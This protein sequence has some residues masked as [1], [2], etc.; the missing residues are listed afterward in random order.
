MENYN[1]FGWTRSYDLSTRTRTRTSEPEHDAEA[2]LVLVT[3]QNWQIFKS[4]SKCVEQYFPGW[5]MFSLKYGE[6]WQVLCLLV[7]R[8]IRWNNLFFTLEGI[9]QN[10]VGY[11][12][13]KIF[14]SPW[15]CTEYLPL[16]VTL[17]SYQILSRIL[18]TSSSLDLICMMSSL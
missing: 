5:Y 17:V 8:S 2:S 3:T 12:L 7:I 1:N 4:L 6:I 9:P 13:Q 10:A 11:W 16:S 14:K 15:I 18:F